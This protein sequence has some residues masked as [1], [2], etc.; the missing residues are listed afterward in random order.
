MDKYGCVLPPRGPTPNIPHLGEV[1]W[2]A[3]SQLGFSHPY[4]MPEMGSINHPK[5]QN[6]RGLLLDIFKDHQI[7]A[8]NW[9][10]VRIFSCFDQ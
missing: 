4:G 9:N 1:S 7:A 3:A 5:R 2:S 10:E 8:E 6:N